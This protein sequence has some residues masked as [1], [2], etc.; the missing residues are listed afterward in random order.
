[1]PPF[2]GAD[3]GHIT[4]P[5]P[6]PYHLEVTFHQVTELRTVLKG[7]WGSVPAEI[8]ALG[9]SGTPSKLQRQLVNRGCLAPRSLKCSW[10]W[11][12]WV[13]TSV[14]AGM[15]PL[16]CHGARM[17]L[18]QTTG[19]GRWEVSPG[20]APLPCPR[21]EHCLCPGWGCRYLTL[22]GF[23]G[24]S[25]GYCSWPRGPLLR[26]CRQ[27]PAQ[28]LGLEPLPG[29]RSGGHPGECWSG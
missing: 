23:G 21:A 24:A 9:L 25:P 20:P 12:W 10:L 17:W 7:W 26:L 3:T 22:T 8:G 27:K 19:S 15:T 1:M 16:S 4:S 6:Q 2:R 13:C 18:G 14:G 28:A 29:R 11:C 5:L